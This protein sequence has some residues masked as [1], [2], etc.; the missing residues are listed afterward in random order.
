MAKLRPADGQVSIVGFAQGPGLLW[1]GL[2]RDS[3]GRVYTANGDYNIGYSIYEINPDTGQ[4]IF[5]VQTALKG[6]FGLAFGP[7]DVLFA[8]DHRNAPVI[9]DVEDLHI[10]DLGTGATTFI[11][12]LTTYGRG[13]LDFLNGVLWTHNVENGLTQIDLNTSTPTDIYPLASAVPFTFPSAF[14]ISPEGTMFFIGVDLWVLDS[15]TGATSRGPEL[16]LYALWSGAVFLDGSPEP[17]ALW[18]GGIPDG[19]M[20]IHV[21]GATPFST[22]HL[23]AGTGHGGSTN[24]PAGFPCSGDKLNLK[25]PVRAVGTIT[26]DIDGKANLGPV[27]VPAAAIGQISV[28]A[29]DLSSCGMTNAAT[30][31]N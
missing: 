26:A 17:F 21:A 9:D 31:W 2:A 15:T 1:A 20:E 19:P 13:R 6:L 11:G 27:F 28:Q 30:V 18:F 10:V 3:S 14:C 22:L 29:I 7:G 25:R 8:Y 16:S 23:L 4:E 24:I 12:E 5:V